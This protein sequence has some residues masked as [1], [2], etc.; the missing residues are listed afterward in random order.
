MFKKIHKFIALNL[1]LLLSFMFSNAY[2]ILDLELTEGVN[3]ALPIAIV[4]FVGQD[5]IT[6]SDKNVHAIISKDLQNS[7]KFRL[8][9]TTNMPN[10]ATID[11]SLWQQQKANDVVVGAVKKSSGGQYQVS[12]TLHDIYGQKVL[13]TKNYTVPA[14]ELRILAHHISDLIYQALTGDHG[15][16]STKIAYVVVERMGTKAKYSLEVADVDGFNPRS[17][18]VSSEPIMSP[19]WSSDGKQIAYVSFEGNR[20]AIYKQNVA[21]GVRS[22]VTKYPG[23]N[24]APAWSPDGS[25]MAVVLTQT[26]YPK[27]YVLNLANNNL[28][29]LTSDWYL[30]TE[31]SWA[32]DGRSIIFTSDRGGSPQI[33]RV[34]LD[35]KKVERVSYNGSYNARALFTPDGKSVVMLHQD[36]NGF[37]IAL[38]DLATQRVNVLTHSGDNESPGVAPNGKMIV[39]ATNSGG[40]GVLA[41]ISVDGGVKLLLP[42]RKGSVQEPAWSPYLTD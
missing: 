29:Q 20:A 12:F 6:D 22:I 27:I 5:I 26:G 3:S 35:S 7:G 19:A 2:A 34:Y 21:T 8:L 11:Y 18:L 42:S 39:Y 24:G 37:A 14:A 32:P 10:S 28:D 38:Q 9:D 41:I 40:K 30:D 23:I 33:Y 25:K 1:L 15:I 17:M 31:P 4:P 16:F 36:G 13:L